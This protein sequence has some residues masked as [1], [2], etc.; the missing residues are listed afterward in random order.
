[1]LNDFD[2]GMENYRLEY[3]LLQKNYVIQLNITIA[4]MDIN[5]YYCMVDKLL[6]LT[7]IRFD[8]LYVV[9]IVARF[10][11]KSQL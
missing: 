1:M 5:Q 4:P 8:L 10:T 3:I 7:N 6:F 11:V 2:F 9:E